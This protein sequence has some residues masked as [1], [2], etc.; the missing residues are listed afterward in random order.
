MRIID[1]TR[2]NLIILGAI[3]HVAIAINPLVPLPDT[4]DSKAASVTAALP[5]AYVRR[6]ADKG[7]IQVHANAVISV[8]E[9]DGWDSA[10]SEMSV[11]RQ[12]SGQ[13]R[14]PARPW[15]FWDQ[16]NQTASVINDHSLGAS[17]NLF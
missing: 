16:E 7:T 5:A 8:D 14:T 6:Q 13:V 2:F 12:G 11:R 15:R 3:F 9:D 4:F 17:L 1:N 10:D